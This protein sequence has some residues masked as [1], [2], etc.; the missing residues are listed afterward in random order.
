MTLTAWAARLRNDR[1]TTQLQ[2]TV[3]LARRQ[4]AQRYRESIFGGAWALLNPL[5]L[6]GIYWVVFS[7]VFESEWSGPGADRPYALLM[8]SGLVFFYL[9]SEIVNG[10]AF[11]V[12][13]SALLIKRTTV[14]ARVIPLAATLAALFT[15]GLNLI[16]FFVM[17]VVLEREP[18]PATA[19][20]LPLIVL[21]LLL[22]ATGV[23]FVIA[24]L[25]AYFRDLQQVVPLINTSVLFLSPIFFPTE[26]LPENFQPIVERFTPLGPILPSSKRLLFLGELPDWSALGFYTLGAS[27]VFAFGW[28]VYGRLARG[29]ADVV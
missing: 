14:S 9:W 12:Q 1:T 8:F 29:F 17:Y 28:F 21:P 22:L 2:L 10:S 24:G 26:S 23:A 3:R 25:S 4:I 20:L 16:P 5:I 11:L 7:L 6:L 19:L 27:L 13:S 18:P 15:F